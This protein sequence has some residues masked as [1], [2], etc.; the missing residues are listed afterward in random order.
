[1]A[2]A[3]SGLWV[4][5]KAAVPVSRTTSTRRSSTRVE[6]AG[7]RLPVGSSARRRPGLL[8][9]GAG[10]GDPLLLAAGQRPA[11]VEA[12][13]EPQAAEQVDCPRSGT[14]FAATGEELRQHDVFLGG[15]IGEEVVELID[16]A[17]AVAAQ[18]GALAIAESAAGPAVDDDLAGGRPLEQGGDVEQRR[19]AGAGWPDQGDE[20]AGCQ[21]EIGAPE[22]RQGVAP[23]RK[24]CSMRSDQ[25]RFTHSAAPLPDRRGPPAR[26]GRAWRGRRARGPSARPG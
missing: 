6:V 13:G 8:A 14:R 11:M 9:K 17:D 22:H 1:M 25:H 26:P 3:I 12:L 10:D 23:W 7:S 15:E 5:M 21:R 16:E 24:R 18:A 2:A 4:A 19:L 20:L